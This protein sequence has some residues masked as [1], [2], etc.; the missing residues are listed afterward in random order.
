MLTTQLH[1]V[2]L[3][4]LRGHTPYVVKI[5]CW[6]IWYDILTAIG[7]TRGGSG[8]VHIYTQ[9]QYTEQHN[10]TEYTEQNIHKN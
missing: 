7:L 1:L 4:V 2:P 3:L 5:C 10:E 9:T 8:T 6:I